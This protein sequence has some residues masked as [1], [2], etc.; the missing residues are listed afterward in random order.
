MNHPDSGS[1]NVVSVPNTVVPLVS[2]NS[3]RHSVIISAPVTNRI[4]ISDRPGMTIDQGIN[5][6]VGGAAL[7][8]NAD[9]AG[10]WVQRDL[11]AVAAAGT[12][13]IGVL[14]VIC[15]CQQTL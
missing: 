6:P 14:E 1:L 13:T 15:Q 9:T 8:L 7:V 10:N 12:E 3:M 4:T 5:I 2:A 11:F